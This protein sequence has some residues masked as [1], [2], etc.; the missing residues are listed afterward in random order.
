VIPERTLSAQGAG[1]LEAVGHNRGMR[2]SRVLMLA[3]LGLVAPSAGLAASGGA[4]EIAYDRTVDGAGRVTLLTLATGRVRV[5]TPASGNEQPVWAPGGEALVVL[6]AMG[7]DRS[8]LVRVDVPSGRSRRL[9]PARGTNA[10]PAFAPNGRALAWTAGADGRTAIW[11]MAADGTAKRRLTPGPHDVHP[12]WSPAGKQIAYVAAGGALR[13]VAAA[14]GAPRT[15][16]LPAVSTDAAPSWSPDGRLLAVAGAD[17]ALYVAGLAGG[18]R[19]IEPGLPHAHAWR[20]VWA[21]RGGRIAYLDLVHGG[22]LRIVP[23]TGGAPRTLARRTDA[24]DAPAW[25]PDG[26]RLA[27]A[28]AARHLE[29]VEATGGASRV[30]THGITFDGDPAW[31]P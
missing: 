28:D 5:V 22:A 21:P 23:A 17:G 26:R 14:G 1:N 2:R 29:V 18:V 3:L 12:S 4:G 11:R 6:E 8:R 16:P 15:L 10:W 30:V 13:V 24:L 20:P 27:F 7:I 19:R 25:S 31:R 9:T